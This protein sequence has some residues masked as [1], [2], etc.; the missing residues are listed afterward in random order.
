VG[1]KGGARAGRMFGQGVKGIVDN[2]TWST[3]GFI[4]AEARISSTYF[5]EKL[6]KPMAREQI[7]FEY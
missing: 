6:D 1:C 3:T 5:S 7:S 4:S 2:R